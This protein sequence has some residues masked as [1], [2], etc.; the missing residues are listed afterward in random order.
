MKSVFVHTAYIVDRDRNLIMQRTF[1]KIW[2][3]EKWAS[4]KIDKHKKV[5]QWF[6]YTVTDFKQTSVYFFQ[7]VNSLPKRQGIF[8]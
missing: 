2:K 4:K 1:D 3:A 6:Y 7:P 5:D 8:Q